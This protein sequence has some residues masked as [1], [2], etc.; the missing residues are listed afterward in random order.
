MTNPFDFSSARI[1]EQARADVARAPRKNVGVSDLT[2]TG[3]DRLSVVAL[4]KDLKAVD[5]SMR[6]LRTP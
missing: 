2:A 4:I 5:F 1:A 3:V 6:F